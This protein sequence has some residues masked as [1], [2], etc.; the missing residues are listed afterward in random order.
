MAGIVNHLE[1]VFLGDLVDFLN[2]A[3][4]SVDVYGHDCACS[5]SDEAFEF[6]GVERKVFGVYVAENWGQAVADDCVSG[7]GER[8]RGGDDFALKI[9]S[10]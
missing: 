2:V 10:L 8:E 9:H 1:L 7:G 3:D 4:I 5:V 6:C